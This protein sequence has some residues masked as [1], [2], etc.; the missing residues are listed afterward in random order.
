VGTH[1]DLVTALGLCVVYRKPASRQI[2]FHRGGV[3]H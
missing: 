1:D 3:L 2:V